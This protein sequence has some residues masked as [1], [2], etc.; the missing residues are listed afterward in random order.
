MS[1]TMAA[2]DG[3][4]VTLRVLPLRIDSFCL[5]MVAMADSGKEW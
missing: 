5:W 2:D 1:R 3:Y 4:T